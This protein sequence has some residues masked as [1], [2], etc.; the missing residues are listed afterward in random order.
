MDRASYDRWWGLLLLL[1]CAVAPYGDSA[2][3]WLRDLL[4][5][6]G[7][8]A[9]VAWL[10][11]GSLAGLVA[12]VLGLSRW[13]ARWRHFINLVLGLLT[14]AVPLAAPV[15]WDRY[16]YASPASLPL[17]DLQTIGWV[18][19]VGMAALYVGT[20]VRIV[21]PSQ[22]LGQVLG[23]IGAFLLLVFVCLP[24]KGPN[25]SAY[26]IERIQAARESTRPWNELLPFLLFSAAVL[27]GIANLVRTRYEVVL[28]KL[29]RVFLLG[30][31]LF[32]IALPFADT[33]A[34]LARHL[35]VAWGTLRLLGP[36]FLAVD[37]AIAFIAIS[38]TRDSS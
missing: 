14:L 19:L 21:R 3:G 27:F 13:Q 24:A 32:W 16:P 8:P 20:G 33:Q 18:M 34:A 10:W 15:I 22:P 11:L 23:A 36:L 38:V 29:T 2:I 9:V 5:G 25:N 7:D 31:L 12:F 17:S 1:T 37:G 28:A 30:A 26:V 6:E 4:R 35:P